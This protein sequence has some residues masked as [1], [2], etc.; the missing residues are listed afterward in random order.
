M[1]TTSADYTKVIPARTLSRLTDIFGEHYQ[2]V[3]LRLS[4]ENLLALRERYSDDIDFYYS[5]MAGIYM[6]GGPAAYYSYWG[7]F[8]ECEHELMR[9][10]HGSVSWQCMLGDLEL[11]A[12]HR[13]ST[14][15][16]VSAVAPAWL[17]WCDMDALWLLRQAQICSASADFNEWI[18]RSEALATLAQAGANA[19]LS[20]D[21]A[22]I[23]GAN[24][25]R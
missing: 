22:K 12:E 1:R 15:I 4:D 11:R 25:A 20:R 3:L 23:I 18:D 6:T 17:R 19:V 8:G 21:V 5:I 7:V 16:I 10:Y 2:L 14:F 24:N 9:R 13:C